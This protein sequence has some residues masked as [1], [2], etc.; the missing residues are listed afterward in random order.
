MYLED[1]I[2]LIRSA[3]TEAGGQAAWA[4]QIGEH[5]Q[6]INEVIHYRRRPTPK[7]CK[8]LNIRPIVTYENGWRR[9]KG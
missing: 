7:M 6:S 8:A 5:K 3:C 4:R 9:R 1:V 2:H